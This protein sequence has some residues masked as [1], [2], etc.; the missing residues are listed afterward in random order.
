MQTS[1]WEFA[2]AETGLVNGFSLALGGSL[3][4]QD[5]HAK[6]DGRRNN[7]QLDGLYHGQD[8]QVL[9]HSMFVAHCHPDSTSS[10]TFKGVL[11]GHAKGVFQAKTLVAKGAD[12]T[13][14]HQL[15]RAL[16]LSPTAEIDAK[17]ELEIYLMTS[18]ALTVLHR[19][20]WIRS[21]ILS[22]GAWL[23]AAPSARYAY[24]RL[25]A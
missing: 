17:P 3:V 12:K 15:N 8:K 13:D 16:L 19:E 21:A 18:N 14:G 5:L 7:F 10:L 11:D 9:D 2:V 23:F 4:R 25:F 22:Y 20:I 1:A 24:S 6:L